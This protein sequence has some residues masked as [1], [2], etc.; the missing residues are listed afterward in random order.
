[1]TAIDCVPSLRE[2]LSIADV[3]TAFRAWLGTQ[4]AELKPFAHGGTDEVLEKCGVGSGCS[5][6]QAGCALAGLRGW[7]ASGDRWPYA[8]W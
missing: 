4:T 2:D 7:A 1:M 3:R 6:R 5:I 8:V